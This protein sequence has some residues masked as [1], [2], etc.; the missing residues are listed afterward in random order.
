[1]LISTEG[2]HSG[3]ASMQERSR[4]TSTH[5]VTPSCPLPQRKENKACWH[6]KSPTLTTLLPLSAIVVTPIFKARKEKRVAEQLLSPG[7]AFCSTGLPSCFFVCIPHCPF[8]SGSARGESSPRRFALRPEPNVHKHRHTLPES[9]KIK[10]S[11]S[12]PGQEPR[13]RRAKAN[14]D[15]PSLS[16]VAL[17]SKATGCRGAILCRRAWALF[18]RC[19]TASL[20][21]PPATE[22]R[23]QCASRNTQ[24]QPGCDVQAPNCPCPLPIFLASLR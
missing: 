15:A 10:R 8:G 20:L 22:Q 9:V 12:Q 16:S 5:A 14:G 1:M 24:P 13:W 21:V 2:R 7:G 18:S 3:S 6:I 23:L 19:A 4:R 17:G 11:L